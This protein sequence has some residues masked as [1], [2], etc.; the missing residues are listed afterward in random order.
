MR[1]LEAGD[2]FDPGSEGRDAGEDGRH[3]GVTT[4]GTERYDTDQLVV[5]YHRATRVTLGREKQ[6]ALAT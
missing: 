6:E 5:T 4:G 3:V 2:L 1:L